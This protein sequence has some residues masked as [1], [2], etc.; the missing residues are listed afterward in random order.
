M[1]IACSAPDPASGVAVQ[2]T[3]Y[4][5]CQA[6]ALGEN[7]FQAIA[8]GALGMSLLTGLLT[9]FVAFIGYR[10]ILGETP[11]ARDGVGWA[12][13]V[14]LVL[15][16][17][18]SWP[19]FQTLVFRVVVDGPV[20]L[21]NLVMPASGLPSEGL[22]WRVQQAYE[23][24][25]LGPTSN[26]AANPTAAPT[27]PSP[28]QV[29]GPM[30]YT[31]STFVVSTSGF[32]GA[33]R[34][35]VGFLLAVAPLAI[36]CLLFDAT[37]GIFSSWVRALSGM[38]L[39]TLAA[40]IVTAID[41]MIVESQ[42]AYLQELRA[43]GNL[44]AADPQALTTAVLSFALIML[45]TAVA[46]MRMTSAFRLRVRDIPRVRGSERLQAA[47]AAGAAQGMIYRSQAAPE[48]ITV[49]TP[50]P[51][52]GRAAAVA[53][54]LAAASRRDQAY[55]VDGRAG[56]RQG[57]AANSGGGS[58]GAEGSVGGSGLGAQ[59]RRTIGRRTQ[60]A[61]RRDKSGS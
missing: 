7:G 19:A 46:A 42:I 39:A 56:G 1:N 26:L 25:R 13:R 16:L 3:Y 5:D 20:E 37:L 30:P 18:M 9:I 36:L 14:G 49:H 34:I 11:G 27:A 22:E 55:L 17:M 4:L 52:Q 59:G 45:I 12:V 48:A 47:A 8:G 53:G 29:H 41:L 35:A 38:A 2:L 31:A 40:T 57:G 44:R 24:I 51:A 32:T 21:A 50:A 10:L 43:A 58:S 60:S 61:M 6:R 15:A 33:F 54:S 28:T 23:A